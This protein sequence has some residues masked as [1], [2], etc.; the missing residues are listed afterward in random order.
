METDEGERVHSV[1]RGASVGLR[2]AGGEMNAGGQIFN[3][4]MNHWI[5]LYQ[6]LF[7]L[8]PT[9]LWFRGSGV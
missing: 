1:G 2:S 8:R 4:K 3:R 7:T 6:G 9:T 5:S